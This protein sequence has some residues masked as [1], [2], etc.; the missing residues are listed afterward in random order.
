MTKCYKFL[1]L[2]D[3]TTMRLGRSKHGYV[4]GKY[5]PTHKVVYDCATREGAV[6]TWRKLLTL[7]VE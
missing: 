2:S 1:N 7:E 3:G 6:K 5:G 4:V